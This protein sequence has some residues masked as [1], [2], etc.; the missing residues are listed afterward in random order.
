LAVVCAA[1]FTLLFASCFSDYR[2][3][4][5]YFSIRPQANAGA[6]ASYAP[7]PDGPETEEFT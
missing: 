5:G 4:H 7:S 3:D 2:G 6:A 1:L